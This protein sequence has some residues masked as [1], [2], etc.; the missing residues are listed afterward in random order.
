VAFPAEEYILS[1]SRFFSALAWRKPALPELVE[2]IVVGAGQAGLATSH[3]LTQRGREHVILERGRV[4]ERWR[5]ERWDSLYFQFPNWMMRLPDH[6]YAGNDPDGFS[7]RDDVVRFITDYGARTAAPVRCGVNVTGLRQTEDGGLLVQ[8]GPTSIATHN[9]VV[10]TGPYQVPTLP[11]CAVRLPAAICQVTA[12]RYTR[13]SELPPGGVLVVGSGASGCQIVEDLLPEGRNVY[14]SLRGHRRMPRRYRGRDGGTWGEE[15]GVTNR[16]ADM[17]PPGFRTPLVTGFQGGKTV[18]LHE[19]A[20]RGVRLLGSLQDIHDGRISFATDLNKNLEAGD[21]TFRQWV[22]SVD[23][24]IAASGIDAP[25]D[26]EFEEVLRGRPARLPEIE[27]LDL[28]DAGIGTVIWALGYGYDFSWIG[29]DVL[30]A[31]GAPL[32]QRGVTSVPGLYFLGLP[33]MHKVKSSFLWGVGEDAEFLA[34]HMEQR[35]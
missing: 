19:M 28:R 26:R 4:A 17:I 13:P 18:D 1:A 7:Q 23:A 3:H 16:T 27:V 2:T 9:V 32:Q 31:R 14:Y 11:P 24:Y 8:A 10:A 22:S 12:S 33:R 5:S 15:M 29:C 30:D 6:A 34:N 25:P 35:S 20:Q 21:E